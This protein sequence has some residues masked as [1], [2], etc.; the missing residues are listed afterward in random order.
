MHSVDGDHEFRLL[1]GPARDY[2][3]QVT[4]ASTGKPLPGVVVSGYGN[5]HY[6]NNRLFPSHEKI[7]S[8]TNDSGEVTV[9]AVTTEGWEYYIDFEK[10]GFHAAII[11]GPTSDNGSEWQISYKDS[12]RFP[13]NDIFEGWYTLQEGK[14]AQV[15]MY[16]LGSSIRGGQ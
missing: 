3:F 5:G 8:L 2:V 4:D 1:T 13:S 7:H 10:P 12:D 11:Y 15:K 9:N 6:H 16:H 14:L